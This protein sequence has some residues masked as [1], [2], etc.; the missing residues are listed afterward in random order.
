MSRKIGSCVPKSETENWRAALF[1]GDG[2][3]T[4]PAALATG[5]AP[6][7]SQPGAPGGRGER[8]GAEEKRALRG[9]RREFLEKAL[10]YARCSQAAYEVRMEGDIRNLVKFALERTDD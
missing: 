8:E 4:P 3:F 9:E 7:A 1:C 5:P 6:P 10:F 2:S